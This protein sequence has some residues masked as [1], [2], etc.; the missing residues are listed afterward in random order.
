MSPGSLIG[1]LGVTLLLM[2]F[3][4]N[5]TKTLSAESIPYL[6]LNLFGAALACVSSYLIVFWP[7]VV[8]EAI[9]VLATLAALIK[10]LKK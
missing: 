3:A 8:L 1:T 6:L 4:L 9:W 10:V 5:I 2:A 7:F